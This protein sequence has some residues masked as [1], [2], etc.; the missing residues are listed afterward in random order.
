VDPENPATVY[1][2]DWRVYKSTDG[3][4]TWGAGVDPHAL[5]PT[6]ELSLD[7]SDPRIVYAG[8]RSFGGQLSRSTDGGLSFQRLDPPVA[9]G[10]RLTTDFAVDPV[11][12]GVIYVGTWTGV[13]KSVDGGRTWTSCGLTAPTARPEVAGPEVT[14]LRVAPDG[15]VLLGTSLGL[16][17]SEDGCTSWHAATDNSPAHATTVLFDPVSSKLL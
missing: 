3:G 9:P 15:A 17:R 12:P 16:R 5:A 7:A 11:R 2:A 4:I 8:P 13:V 14:G 1:A 6:L 10:Q